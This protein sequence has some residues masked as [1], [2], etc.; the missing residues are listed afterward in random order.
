MNQLLGVHIPLARVARLLLLSALATCGLQSC[1]NASANNLP[2]PVSGSV[3]LTSYTQ[4][5]CSG[6][7]PA[8][9]CMLSG[10]ITVVSVFA[11]T[12]TMTFR[13]GDGNG[14]F[15]QSQSVGGSNPGTTTITGNFASIGRSVACGTQ[16]TLTILEVYDA[17]G[18]KVTNVSGTTPPIALPPC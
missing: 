10:K 1:T 9:Q 18:N 8:E 6:S 3:T 13:L 5:S 2:V 17:N 4:P 12:S 14:T 15:L 7:L 16:I 11:P